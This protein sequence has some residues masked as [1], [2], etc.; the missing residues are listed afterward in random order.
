M[1]IALYQKQDPR[2]SIAYIVFPVDAVEL[3]AEY[4]QLARTIFDGKVWFS[5]F[6]NGTFERPKTNPPLFKSDPASINT[7]IS[8]TQYFKKADDQQ[9]ER[10]TELIN[11]AT[12]LIELIKKEYHLEW[13]E[14]LAFSYEL[15]AKQL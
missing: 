8:E 14:L 3:R 1:Q 12:T 15:L 10:I 6:N 7:L 9:V 13:E 5:M 2:S 4:R 11:L